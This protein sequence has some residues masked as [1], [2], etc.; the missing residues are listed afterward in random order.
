MSELK[1]CPFWDGAKEMR[2][3]ADSLTEAMKFI[4]CLD[5]KP[6]I[7]KH[8]AINRAT[9]K[10]VFELAKE[11]CPE[12]ADVICWSL[13]HQILDCQRIAFLL[14]ENDK[15]TRASQWQP[16][17]TYDPEKHP[18]W[19][20]I[21]RGD[22]IVCG[23]FHKGAWFEACMPFD[24]PTHWMPLPEPPEAAASGEPKIKEMDNE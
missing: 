22:E 19:V 7:S 10:R 2:E 20:L 12:A 3:R 24:T 11:L 1:P 6:A 14:D 17:E 23:T 4:G 8:S 5:H 9:L 18:K 21:V 16:I 15:N 13:W